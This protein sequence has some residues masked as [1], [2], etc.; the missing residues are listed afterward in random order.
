MSL[1]PSLFSHVTEDQHDAEHLAR[2]I[3]DRG[4]A[5]VNRSLRAVPGDQDSVVRQ[6][7]YDTFPQHTLD[8]VLG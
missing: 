4:G 2:R 1:Q 6:A 7:H 3:P 5:V 8:R